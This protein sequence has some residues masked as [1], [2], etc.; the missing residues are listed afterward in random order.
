MAN[1]WILQL[2]EPLPIDGDVRLLRSG[3]LADELVRRG[4]QVEWFTGR[5]DHTS[6]KM[7]SE[8]GMVQLQ[9]GLRLVLLSGIPYSTNVSIARILNHL[10]TGLHFLWI[11]ISRGKPDIII[12]SYPSPELAW[13]GVLYSW[14]QH[15]PVVFDFRDAWPDIFLSYLSPILRVACAPLVFIYDLLLRLILRAKT[16]RL[17]TA[18]SKRLLQ[19]ATAH[20]ASDS[21]VTA[22]VFF[23]AYP[24]PDCAPTMRS[25]P[26]T[27]DEKMI[28][29]YAGSLGQSY[30]IERLL[31][32]ARLLADRKED[33]VEFQIAGAGERLPALR[34]QA[35]DLSN[36]YFSG[37]LENSRLQDLLKRAHIGAMLIQGGTLDYTLPNK[38]GEYLAYGL[39]VISN[40]GGDVSEVLSEYNAGLQVSEQDNEAVASW[41]Q[42]L[43]ANPEAYNHC[44]GAAQ[45]AFHDKFS[46]ETVYGEFLKCA[47][48]QCGIQL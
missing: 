30:D 27:K 15:T 24:P 10:M 42:H 34:E 32:I 20:L 21:D 29:T 14:I 9:S 18:P 3:I 35:R 17:L 2:A 48:V 8:S 28:V 41:L 39:P 5:F 45:R 19:V 12:V 4:H 11:S 22:R 1:V 44:Q 13:A 46:A 6:K 38:F 26:F 43:A 16:V 47:S 36:V 33:R 31:Q 37:W 7:R 40:V 25:M 23:L